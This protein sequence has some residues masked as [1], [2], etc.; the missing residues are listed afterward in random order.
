VKQNKVREGKGMDRTKISMR[1]LM[2]HVCS[3]QF[4]DV[5]GTRGEV[6]NALASRANAGEGEK[7]AQVGGELRVGGGHAVVT[8]HGRVGP[9]LR[10]DPLEHL[11][12]RLARKQP[13]DR[14][15]WEQVPRGQERRK[16]HAW[17][18]NVAQRDEAHEAAQ[19]RIARIVP[20]IA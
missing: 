17:N 19:N 15:E 13:D 7:D 6:G 20:T 18:V 4:S 14:R 2:A 3:L 11:V 9:W 8:A 5:E 1:L 12:Q 10:K 16:D